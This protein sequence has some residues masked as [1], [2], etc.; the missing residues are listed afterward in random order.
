[1]R[2]L[3][4]ILPTLLAACWCT[5]VLATEKSDLRVLYV[6]V[7]PETAQLSDMESTFQTAPDRLLEFKKAR[8]PSFER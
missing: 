1:M 2:K 5:A 3:S 7:N 6:G 4:V 8:T